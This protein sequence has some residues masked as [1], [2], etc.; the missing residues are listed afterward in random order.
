M[1]QQTN[2]SSPLKDIITTYAASIKDSPTIVYNNDAEIAS[3]TLD[4]EYLSGHP[5]L[6]RDASMSV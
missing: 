6:D 5:C 4:V 1:M 2:P 3:P